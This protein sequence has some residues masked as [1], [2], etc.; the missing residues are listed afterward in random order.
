MQTLIKAFSLTLIVIIVSCSKKQD[1]EDA[2]DNGG[3]ITI[4]SEKEPKNDS[5]ALTI[6]R[7]KMNPIPKVL[8]REYEAGLDDN[9]KLVLEF[10][11]SQL[12]SFTDSIDWDDNLAPSKG[13]K[14]PT[15]SNKIWSS[16]LSSKSGFY[17]TYNLPNAEHVSVYIADDLAPGSKRVFLFWHET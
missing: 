10:P 13:R 7:I 4:T 3:R 12:Q 17:G 6:V 14:M 5:D 8:V 1:N 2:V 9:M 11:S 15:H 16:H